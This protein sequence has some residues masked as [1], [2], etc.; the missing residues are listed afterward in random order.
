MGKREKIRD[1]RAVALKLFWKASFLM[2]GLTVILLLLKLDFELGFKENIIIALEVLLTYFASPLFIGYILFSLDMMKEIDN[3]K[4]KK[5]EEQ[6]ERENEAK[7]G[8]S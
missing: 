3:D 7:S 4:W 1:K 5:Q 2:L 8:E 6:E